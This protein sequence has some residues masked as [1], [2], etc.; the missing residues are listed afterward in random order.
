MLLAD[1]GADVIAVAGGRAGVAL[2]TVGRGKRVITL[3][4]K[5]P[6]GR[7]AL[8]ALVRRADVFL[9]GF[10]PGVCAT[11]GAG[12]EDLSALN[13]RLVYCSLTGYGQA[14]PLSQVASHDIDYLA[15]GG[16]LGSM[17]PLDGVPVPPLN[18]VADMGGG[19]LY[20]VLGI[21]A[22]LHARAVT[23]QGSYVDVAML[24]GV[25]S[26]MT[27]WYPGWG[28]PT[29]PGRGRGL[30]GGEAPFYRC[31]A[32]ADGRFVAVGAIEPAFF[33]ALWHG[34][35]ID[36]PQPDHLDRRLW[37]ELTT[38]F[39]AI[40]AGR[41]RDEWVER[42]ATLDA[43]VAPVLAPDEVWDHPQIAFRHPGA[44]AAQVPSAP[45]FGAAAAALPTYDLDDATVAVLHEAGLADDDID[46]VLAENARQPRA[47]IGWPPV[48]D[49]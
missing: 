34:L 18:L 48:R 22:A 9:E 42:L 49:G 39:S 13:P 38:R 15:V 1:M 43:C 24:D 30:A 26:L 47:G 19:A 27:M 3:N 25:L 41:P 17:G 36:D 31:Y 11:L 45:R 40:F 8:H 32:C 46:R 14:G 35:G 37:P 6:A 23:G 44:S 12:Y 7:A 21:L 5:E 28:S 29:L 10:R 33:T 20:A 4:L 16:L 2:P